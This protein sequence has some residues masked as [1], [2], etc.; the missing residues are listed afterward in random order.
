MLNLLKSMEIE[1][2]HNSSN[3]NEKDEN[4]VIYNGNY[5]ENLQ[6]YLNNI[7]KP[8]KHSCKVPIYKK[9]PFIEKNFQ[10]FYL[11]KRKFKNSI[12][13]KK[14]VKKIKNFSYSSNFIKKGA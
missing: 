13:L 4:L 2:S 7:K 8:E 9:D 10:S 1:S 11:R 12:I 3:E 5:D 14:N 6:K